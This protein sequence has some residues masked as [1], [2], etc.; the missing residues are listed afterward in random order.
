MPEIFNN[1]INNISL[2]ITKK[3]YKNVVFFDICSVLQD[4]IYYFSFGKYLCQK[5]KFVLAFFVNN[6]FK[7]KIFT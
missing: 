2:V 1:E 6:Q 5:C 4:S 7:I 3:I